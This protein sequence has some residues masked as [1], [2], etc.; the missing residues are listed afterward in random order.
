MESSEPRDATVF[1]LE[2]HEVVRRG[3]KDLLEVDG[4]IVVVGEA[5]PRARRL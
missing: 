5:R 2:D 4:D 1:L 3:V